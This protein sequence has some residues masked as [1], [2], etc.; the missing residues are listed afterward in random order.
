MD[1]S[2]GGRVVGRVLVDG[3]LCEPGDAAISVFDVGLQRGFGCF[4][5]LRSY[6]GKPFRAADHVRRL[7][8]S[9]Y[10]LGIPLPDT[11]RIID[12]I[13]DRSAAGGDCA[14]RVIVSGGLDPVR[15]GMGSRVIVYAEPLPRGRGPL[16]VLPLDAPWHPDGAASELTGAKTLSYGPNLAA[17]LAARRAGFDD[18]LL[19][20]RSGSVLEGPTY[21]VAWAKDGVLETPSLDLGILASITRASVLEVAA[22][23]DISVLEGRFRLKR[24]L[25]ADEVFALST[26]KEVIPVAIVGDREFAAG[27]M[28]AALGRGFSAL[29]AAELESA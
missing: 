6:D 3:D 4:E 10:K 22:T 2:L 25:G 18:A 11:N 12:W 19:V 27:P 5:A 8:A 20:G 21:G 17:T 13:L 29:V 23:L 16:R 15:P 24:V 9:A 7:A 14:I 28:A 26:L 1:A